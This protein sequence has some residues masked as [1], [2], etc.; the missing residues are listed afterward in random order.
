MVE[1]AQAMIYCA[2]RTARIETVELPAEGLK[3]E[4]RYSGLSRG[5]ERLIFNGSV[6]PAEYARM[7]APLQVGE[8]P[9]PVRYGYSAVGTATEGDLAG[10]TVF[11][12]HPHQTAFRADPA[13]LVRVPDTVPAA[14]AILAANMETALNAI[15]DARLRPGSRCLVVGAGLVGWLIT[16]LLS[17]R[18]DLTC[19]LTDIRAETG[20]KADDFCVRFVT[21][22]AVEAQSFD[23]AFHT[24][25]SASGLQTALDSLDFEGRVIESSWFGDRPVSVSLGA[26][27]HANRLS[28]LSSQV[29]HVATPRRAAMSY[30]D[31]LTRALHALDDPRLDVL[32]TED[33]RFRDL[34]ET[35]P[36]L[37]GD[38]A[39]GIATRIVYD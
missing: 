14:R 6:P 36:R 3:V 29:G 21:P 13:M 25:A 24:S 10:Q 5:T 22:D 32:I 37:L 18:S 4:T 7:R 31:R 30:R 34:P 17:R 2:E 35:L 33:V 16:A 11:C 15:W 28:I 20:V 1:T 23:V 8:F 19:T 9:F 38:S 12:L 27:F 39:P 26:N